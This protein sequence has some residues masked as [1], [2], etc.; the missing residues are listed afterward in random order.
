MVIQRPFALYILLIV[1]VRHF[2]FYSSEICQDR[3]FSGVYVE[4]VLSVASST[5]SLQGSL[6]SLQH[7]QAIVCQSSDV[8]IT[9]QIGSVR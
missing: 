5:K 3:F 1:G 8:Q 2:V 9:Y 4:K 7:F 6:N